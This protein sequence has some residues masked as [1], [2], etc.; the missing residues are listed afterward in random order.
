MK[1]RLAP[2]AGG[3]IRIQPWKLL[4][5]IQASMAAPGVYPPDIFIHPE[6]KR[7]HIMEFTADVQ[8]LQ[9]SQAATDEMTGKL[10]AL[11]TGQLFF[12]R[13]TRVFDISD[14]GGIGTCR[15]GV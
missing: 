2:V 5:A 13:R 7:V 8:V 9:Q 14:H 1:N 6:I 15:T 10:K 4:P 11:Q 3:V 12:T